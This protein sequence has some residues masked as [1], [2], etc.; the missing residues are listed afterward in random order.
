[1]ALNRNDFVSLSLGPR[2][3]D[4]MIFYQ[5][6]TVEASLLRKK[7]AQKNWQTCFYCKTQ[8]KSDDLGPKGRETK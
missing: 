2:S 1:M 3:S 4:F 5:C 6:F 7:F 8:E